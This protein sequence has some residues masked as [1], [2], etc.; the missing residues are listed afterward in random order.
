MIDETSHAFGEHDS[1]GSLLGDLFKV[2]PAGQLQ[3]AVGKQIANKMVAQGQSPQAAQEIADAFANYTPTLGQVAAGLGKTTAIAAPALIAIA[4]PVAV[5]AIAS[6][7]GYAAPTAGETGLAALAG[8]SAVAKPALGIAR[9]MGAAID[10][11]GLNPPA[12]VSSATGAVRSGISTAQSAAGKTGAAPGTPN[13]DAL[14]NLLSSVARRLP[15]AAPPPSGGT[16][17]VTPGP[18]ALPDLL[19]GVAQRA[20]GSSAPPLPAS[21]SSRVRFI[22]PAPTGTIA[23][24]GFAPVL[25]VAS[26]SARP[27]IV[28]PTAAQTAVR[29]IDTKTLPASLVNP[30]LWTV[31]KT[32]Q[33]ARGHS[34]IVSALPQW[35]VFG[36]Q[37]VVKLG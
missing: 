25:G 31:T 3:K 2:S 19:A 11:S 6:M 14:A 9:G 34:V 16:V 10:T 24:T 15:S 12:V 32:G 36:S 28:K 18:N 8:A 13:R 37:H 22:P 17:E 26:S 27:R 20:L 35:L 30:V 7:L 29:T 33:V 21:V 5:P 23:Q 1:I 4:A